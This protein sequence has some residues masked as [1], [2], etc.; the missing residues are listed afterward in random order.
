M[1][2]LRRAALVLVSACAA[3]VVRAQQIPL[4]E[5]LG[6]NNTFK[7]PVHG[8]ALTYPAGWEVRGAHRWGKDNQ[9]NTAVLRAVWP[10]ELGASV[11]W[12]PLNEK[13]EPGNEEA[14]FRD[15]AKR[16]AE[17]RVGGFRDYANVPDSFEFFKIGGR[18]AMRYRA[19]FMRGNQPM[20]EFFTRV[21]GEKTM[22]M[23]FTMVPAGELA[24]LR[25]ELDR[26]MESVRLP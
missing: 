11:Y 18:P 4:A 6:P 17:S 24:S 10:S 26:M 2:T 21:L 16:K 13:P 25:P 19:T 1:K 12:A 8:V 3:A 15:A 20:V 7:D 5:I 9:E 23:L 14:Y 22:V